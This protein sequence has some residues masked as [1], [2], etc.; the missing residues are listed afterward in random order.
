MKLF[1]SKITLKMYVLLF[2]S[3][4]DVELYKSLP[5]AVHGVDFVFEAV[6]DNLDV[7][8]SLFES[9]ISFIL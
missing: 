3:K 5:D 6:V 1:Y 8:R 7:K 4:G 9:K 2:F